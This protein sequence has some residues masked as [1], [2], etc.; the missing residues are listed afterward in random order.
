MRVMRETAPA[1]AEE[2]QVL[3][4]SLPT[5][6]N[7]VLHMRVRETL[8]LP[9]IYAGPDIFSYADLGRGVEAATAI[10]RDAGLRAGYRALLIMENCFA[11]VCCLDAIMA[12]DAW[13]GLANPRLTVRE[14][15][16][17]IDKAK[18]RLIVCVIGDKPEA[19]AL[20]PVGS[21]GHRGTAC[22]NFAVSTADPSVIPE[23]V[24]DRT[25]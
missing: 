10:L 13:A 8:D 11:G 16:V 1:T 25:D 9:V 20:S 14:R 5:R 4:A 23:P 22:G 3:I 12:L 17:M 19:H 2:R 24:P 15:D 6:L 21:S 18:P 7:D